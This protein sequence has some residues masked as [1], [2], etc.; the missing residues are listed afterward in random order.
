MSLS[1]YEAPRQ[2]ISEVI[3][4]WETKNKLVRGLIISASILAGIAIVLAGVGNVIYPNE[5]FP[6][7]NG[8]FLVLTAVSAGI[9]F[10]LYLISIGYVENLEREKKEEIIIEK[11]RRV[12][13]NPDKPQL[14]WDLAR[15][16][17][18]NYLNR[19]L[20]QVSAIFYL[21]VF[22]M[23]V[24]FALII[25]GAI[26]VFEAPENFKPAI[27]VAISGVIVNFIGAS[28]LIIYKSTMEQA[29]DYVNVLERI[30]AVG[31]SVQ[32]IDTIEASDGK[33]KDEAKAELSKKLIDLYNK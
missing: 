15:A 5:D 19:N 33:I 18:E 30:N 20:S 9:S 6:K 32:V 4:A 2:I 12:V 8:V 16:K 22:V 7:E 1:I 13:E 3:K 14:A 25:Y 17:L 23:L 10:L 24:G 21:S 29:K 11:E 28:F 27:V 31:M 26:M